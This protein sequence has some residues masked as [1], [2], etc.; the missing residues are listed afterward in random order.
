MV[1]C[2]ATRSG[3]WCGIGVVMC[4]HVSR[5]SNAADALRSRS[6]LRS[7][8]G[9]GLQGVRCAGGA[10]ELPELVTCRSPSGPLE[11]KRLVTC[12]GSP[13]ISMATYPAMAQG[14]GAL[15][16][17]SIHVPMRAAKAVC[18]ELVWSLLLV[19]ATVQYMPFTSPSDR[20]RLPA[21]DSGGRPEANPTKGLVVLATRG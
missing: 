3:L 17:S 8:C 5:V 13:F 14:A 16:N 10:F 11:A 12:I 9:R 19:F 15:V 20:F 6:A 21:A 7:A 2:S 1:F 18:L 4:S